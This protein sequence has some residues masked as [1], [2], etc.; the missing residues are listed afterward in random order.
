MKNKNKPPRDTHITAAWIG[1]FGLIFAAVIA[2]AVAI[3]TNSGDEGGGGSDPVS[4]E[5]VDPKQPTG[6]PTSLPPDSSVSPSLGPT[7]ESGGILLDLNAA[8]QEQECK[9]ENYGGYGW[10][11]ISPV[12]DSKEYR[13]GLSCKFR[14]S[15]RITGFLEFPVGDD[16]SQ[17]TAVAGIEENAETV[18]FKARFLVLDAITGRTLKEGIATPT[19]PVEFSVPVSDVSRI[20]LF[21]ESVGSAEPLDDYEGV[22]VWANPTLQ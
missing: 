3:L 20:K 19:D 6:T 5:S 18:K 21:V 22:V 15:D 16:R 17:F 14:S 7:A 8:K 9:R 13:L 1:F 12:V 11:E 4:S 10:V 2:G